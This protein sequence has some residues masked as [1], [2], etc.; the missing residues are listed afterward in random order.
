MISAKLGHFLDKPLSPIARHIAISPNVLSL[1]GFALTVTAAVLIPFHTEA[2]GFM[3]LVGGLF[4]LFDGVVARAN[5]KDTKFGALFDSTLDRYADAALFLAVML[6]LF[7]GNDLIGVLFAIGGLVGAFLVS[8]V[9]ARAE[10]L[11]IDC[12]VGLIERPERIV[13]LAF[14]C[15]TGS[16]F[17]IVIVLFVLGH[18]TVIQRVV[19]VYKKTVVSSK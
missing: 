12:N 8:Y 4:D 11:G 6:L 10:G 13:L 16:L 14:G 18:I 19:H 1:T 7:R 9:R 17:M 2:G 15:I 3:I 5:G